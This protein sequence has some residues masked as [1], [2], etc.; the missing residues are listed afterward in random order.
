M[1]ENSTSNIMSNNTM[2]DDNEDDYAISYRDFITYNI[3]RV[4]TRYW[5]PIMGPVGLVGNIISLIIMLKP[6]NRT[7][8][9]QYIWQL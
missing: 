5:F 2:G 1:F 6:S 7:F 8:L 9:Y 4:I 3:G